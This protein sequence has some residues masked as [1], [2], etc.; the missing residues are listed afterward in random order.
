M[1]CEVVDFLPGKWVKVKVE[2]RPEG[3]NVLHVPVMFYEIASDMEPRARFSD[4]GVASLS[5]GLC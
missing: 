1:P 2:T 3:K 5:R 4:D